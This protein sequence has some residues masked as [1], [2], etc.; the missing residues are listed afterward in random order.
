LVRFITGSVGMRWDQRQKKALKLTEYIR[1]IEDTLD[2]ANLEK[3]RALIVTDT[4]YQGA[5]TKVILDALHQRGWDADVISVGLVEGPTARP[6]LE[7]RI[8]ATI[9][10]GQEFTPKIMGQRRLTGTDSAANRDKLFATQGRALFDDSARAARALAL[11][12]ADS[13]KKNVFGE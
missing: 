6:T 3:E 11:E 10:T 7:K 1:N 2:S 4:I 8:K 12:I 5:S 9:T 13:I